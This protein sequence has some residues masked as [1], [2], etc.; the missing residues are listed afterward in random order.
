MPDA[1]PGINPADRRYS[2]QHQWIKHHADGVYRVGVTWWE[3]QRL[4][5]PIH[6]EMPEV[7]EHLE[8]GEMYGVV[9]CMLGAIGELRSP[10]PGVVT[11]VNQEFVDDPELLYV[12]DEPYESWLLEMRPDHAADLD[13]LFDADAYTERTKYAREWGFGGVE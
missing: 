8:A 12:Y 3:H 5:G 9:E 11:S 2:D 4:V 1:P 6:V 10:V 13:A 7:G